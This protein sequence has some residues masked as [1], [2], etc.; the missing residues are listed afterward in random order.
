MCF[1]RHRNAMLLALAAYA[2]VRLRPLTYVTVK[3]VD[4]IQDNRLRIS[5]RHK[6]GSKCIIDLPADLVKWLKNFQQAHNACFASDRTEVEYKEM[7]MFCSLR[8]CGVTNLSSI[9]SCLS[10]KV[11][12]KKIFA[13][14]FRHG[15][16]T[17]GESTIGTKKIADAQQHSESTA[18]KS[19]LNKKQN[20]AFSGKLC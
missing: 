6:T 4:E 17:I 16:H 7:R 12:S 2:P 10:A 14:M 20:S 18:R 9:I 15:M 11:C 13:N 3:C 5:G 8:G 19:Y 1:S